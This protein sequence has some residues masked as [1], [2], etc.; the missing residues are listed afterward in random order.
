MRFAS[1]YRALKL[2]MLC[3]KKPLLWAEAATLIIASRCRSPWNDVSRP[4]RVQDFDILMLR[5]S[6]K[7]GFFPDTFVF[8]GGSV[9]DSDF[10]EEWLTVISNSIVKKTLQTGYPYSLMTDSK[11]PI[12]ARP[13]RSRVPNEIAL[14]ITALR[15]TFEEAGCLF[16]RHKDNGEIFDQNSMSGH[17]M[18]DLRA[19]VQG[20]PQRFIE[21]FKELNCYP[22]V[23]SLVEW[24]DWLTPSEGRRRFDTLFFVICRDEPPVVS[25]DEQETVQD[26]SFTSNEFINKRSA[27]D[28]MLPPPQLYEMLRINRFPSFE[29]FRYFSFQRA[30]NYPTRRWLPV[31]LRC[32]DG[33]LSILPGDCLYPHALTDH[34]CDDDTKDKLLAELTEEWKNR[35]IA[36]HIFETKDVNCLY[37]LSK[38]KSEVAGHWLRV[39]RLATDVFP[40]EGHLMPVMDK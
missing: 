10:D 12:L 9:A 31:P 13:W 39:M 30:R 25:H 5:R 40:G 28:V 36:D 26:S 3:L 1:D 33:L 19:Q 20:D 22:D 2:A 38:D 7:L 4:A 32:S 18:S 16:A 34:E 15:E 11:P 23:V 8:P 6:G 27:G 24:S 14:R 29:Y 17:V 35:T 21:V 37:W